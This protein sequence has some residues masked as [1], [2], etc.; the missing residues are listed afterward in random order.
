MEYMS[1]KEVGVQWGISVRQVQNL[2]KTGRIP[3][4]MK[5]NGCWSIPSRAERPKDTRQKA[6]TVHSK[7]NR[8][9]GDKT[10]VAYHELFKRDFRRMRY[11]QIEGVPFPVYVERLLE[12]CLKVSRVDY[13]VA[14]MHMAFA[15][16]GMHV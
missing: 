1:A 14:L 13:P 2:C 4:V 3:G 12:V 9:T 10:L 11:E 5:R 8:S 6:D 7:A 15:L 16:P